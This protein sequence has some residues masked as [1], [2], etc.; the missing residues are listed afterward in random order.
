MKNGKPKIVT[1]KKLVN[2]LTIM[3]YRLWMSKMKLQQIANETGLKDHSTIS[4]HLKR[5]NDM[6]AVNPKF[7]RDEKDFRMDD[8]KEQYSKFRTA[9][10]T[11]QRE[12]LTVSVINTNNGFKAE[13]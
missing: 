8:F 4:Y 2:G 13:K 12:R 5:Y 9:K 3:C 11:A 6:I 10:S 1:P 7:K